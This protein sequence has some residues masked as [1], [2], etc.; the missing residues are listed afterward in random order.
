MPFGSLRHHGGMALE[1]D[2]LVG[3]AVTEAKQRA[4]DE[5]VRVKV[6]VEGEI[7]SAERGIDR[8]VLKVKDDLVIRAYWG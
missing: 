8:V 2:T 4:E 5:G 3:L 1:V 7:T 6:V